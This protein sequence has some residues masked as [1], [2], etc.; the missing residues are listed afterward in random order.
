MRLQS[1][2]PTNPMPII[3]IFQFQ[4]QLLVSDEINNGSRYRQD[5]RGTQ[6]APQRRYAFVF[7]DLHESILQARRWR[8]T[9]SHGHAT[10]Y[11]CTPE[12]SRPVDPIVPLP[13]AIA[14][15]IHQ[16]VAIQIAFRGVLLLGL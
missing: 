7:S 4:P 13:V 8:F 10:T 12:L 11:E 9:S 1:I 14:V 16:T 3:M 6:S 5:Q 15:V 2:F